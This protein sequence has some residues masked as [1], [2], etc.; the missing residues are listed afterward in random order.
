[1]LILLLTADSKRC[2]L[3]RDTCE[4]AGARVH[5]AGGADD[6]ALIFTVAPDRV[7]LLVLDPQLLRSHGVAMLASWRRMAPR[8]RVLL[9]G[10]QPAQDRQRLTQALQ[11]FGMRD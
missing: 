2:E 10:E 11:S 7:D 6:S 8:A 9:L 5:C 4:G 3:L 1:M